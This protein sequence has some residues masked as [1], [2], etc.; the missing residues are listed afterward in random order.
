MRILEAVREVDAGPIVDGF[1]LGT[2]GRN[3]LFSV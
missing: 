3:R 2:R 1:S